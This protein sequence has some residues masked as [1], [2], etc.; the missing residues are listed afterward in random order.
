MKK[1]LEFYFIAFFLIAIDFIAFAQPSD[2]DS[3]GGLEDG[4]DPQPAPIDSKLL[5]LSIIGV[6]ICFL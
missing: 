1:N 3:G 5:F 6:F 4:G 2:D